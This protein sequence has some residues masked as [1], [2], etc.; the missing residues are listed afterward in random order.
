[1]TITEARANLARV[2]D[3]VIHSREPVILTRRGAE[4]V[5]LVPASDGETQPHHLLKSPANAARLLSALQE[6]L[7]EPG[8]PMT[9]EQLKREVGL[10]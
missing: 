6:S 9:V 1:M 5:A 4:D 10:G 2:W 7:T 3:E 8:N